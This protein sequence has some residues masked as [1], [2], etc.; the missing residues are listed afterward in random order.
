MDLTSLIQL[1]HQDEKLFRAV[2]QNSSR[3]SDEDLFNACREYLKVPK[4]DQPALEYCFLELIENRYGQIVESICYR[5][6]CGPLKSKAWEAIEF[7][8]YVFERLHNKMEKAFF[9]GF[10]VEKNFRKEFVRTL[11]HYIIYYF[12]KDFYAKKKVPP[13][14]LSDEN[15]TNSLMELPASIKQDWSMCPESLHEDSVKRDIETFIA[16]KQDGKVLTKKDLFGWLCD[17][18]TQQ[19]RNALKDEQIHKCTAEGSSKSPRS[20]E[21]TKSILDD[22]CLENENRIYEKSCQDQQNEQELYRLYQRKMKL[23]EQMLKLQQD[24]DGVENIDQL[25]N[26][27]KHYE[28]SEAKIKEIYAKLR[29]FTQL[30]YE[31]ITLI[32]N[33]T[34]DCCYKLRSQLCD[35]WT[36]RF[37]G[38]FYEKYEN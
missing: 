31:T 8:D 34:I 13:A 5:K 23:M 16:Q 27:Q 24:N 9:V 20:F 26:Q 29:N 17:F 7:R 3:I 19:V 21:K 33:T 2:L 22:A 30:S 36:E 38:W 18:P 25:S 12:T 28:R 1:Y 37:K 35:D 14:S 4:L 10:Q 15:K 11:S 6:I 32:M